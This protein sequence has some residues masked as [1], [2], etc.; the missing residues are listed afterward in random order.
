MKTLA[1]VEPRTPISSAPLVIT[2]P[3]AYYL[4]TNL[5]GTSG[6]NGI[7]IPSGSVTL[8][9]N[10]NALLG[11]LGSLEGILFSG[12]ETN[13]TMRNGTVQGWGVYDRHPA[14]YVHCRESLHKYYCCVRPL[15]DC[16]GS[17]S[18]PS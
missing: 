7:V 9:L 16:A 13:I 3:D 11:V 6:T 8:D 18:P 15:C 14:I 1:Q 2:N 12:N 10:G 5:V 4:P 17:H